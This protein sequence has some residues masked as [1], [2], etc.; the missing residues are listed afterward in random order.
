MGNVQ[1]WHFYWPKMTTNYI[2]MENL[3]NSSS[4]PHD[5]GIHLSDLIV[6]PHLN[7]AE[8][9]FQEDEYAWYNSDHD[10]NVK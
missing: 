9:T 2:K 1:K 3:R 6:Y 7:E 5:S 8:Q 4:Q 10:L